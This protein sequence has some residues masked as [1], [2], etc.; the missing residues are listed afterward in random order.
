MSYN[1]S[2][3][4]RLF[5]CYNRLFPGMGSEIWETIGTASTTAK[6]NGL[7]GREYQ[8]YIE[9]KILDRINP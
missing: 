5:A 7:Q 6:N 9:G 3:E 4:D 2:I 1:I 8:D